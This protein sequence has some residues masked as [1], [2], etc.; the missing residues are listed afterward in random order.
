MAWQSEYTYL[1]PF[2]LNFTI[3]TIKELITDTRHH[4]EEAIKIEY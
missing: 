1:L 4:R 3:K 2:A